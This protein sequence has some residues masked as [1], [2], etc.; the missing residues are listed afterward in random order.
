M[1][2]GNSQTSTTNTNTN[3]QYTPASY[4]S[5]AAQNNLNFA[6][7]L[8]NNGFQPYT[9]QQVANFSPQQTA[10]FDMGTGIAGAVTPNVQTAGTNLGNFLNNTQTGP[11]IT[12]ETISSQMSP[13]MNQ[14]VNL[15]LQPQIAAANN[16]F[17]LN[18]QLMQGQATSAGAFGDPR[19]QLLQQNQQLNNNLSMQGLVGNA[20]NAAFNTAIGAGA[21]DVSN[22]LNAQIAT[23]QLGLGTQAQQLAG[24]NTAF[25]QGVTATNL[26]NTLGSQQTAQSQAQLNAMYNQWLMAQQYPFQTGQL[27]NQTLGAAVPA[28]PSTSSS[29]QQAT[30][31]QP[32]NSG[33][34]ILGSVAGAALAPFTGGLSLGLGSVLGSAASGMLS[35]PSS[36]GYLTPSQAYG[37]G[38][39]PVSLPNPNVPGGYIS[40][41]AKGGRPTPNKPA[42]VGEKG[43]ELFVPDKA[44]TVVPYEKLREAM[45]KKKG[46]STSGLSRQL[47]AAA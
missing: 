44:G 25:G 36:T 38:A 7:N 12:P 37:S 41:Y 2:F 35:S 18:Q 20:Y 28:S 30:T 47:G 23:G 42:I 32:N 29:Q 14:Y 19:A 3:S 40:G 5:S 13:Y 43:P 8:Q 11:T 26:Q 39:S 46:L 4:L 17:A 45:A 9:G 16:Q 22:N 33:W 31:T 10:S 27:S 6:S 21:Q 15:A 1:C 24:I 34:G